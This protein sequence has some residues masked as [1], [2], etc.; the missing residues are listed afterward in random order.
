MRM[1]RKGFSERRAA[2]F[3]SGRK[4]AV[5]VS[6]D[7]GLLKAAKEHGVNLSQTLE[8]AVTEALK[9]IQ[10]DRWLEENRE[11]IE[12]YNRHIEKHGVFSDG[13]RR[14]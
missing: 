7:D 4:K 10:R 5:N 11:A 14:F 1:D 6:I 2:A 9:E 12:S 8:R 13:L 3:S